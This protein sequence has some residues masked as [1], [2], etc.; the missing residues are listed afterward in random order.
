[1]RVGQDLARDRGE[2]R[3]ELGAVERWMERKLQQQVGAVRDA[4]AP[5]FAPVE[6]AVVADPRQLAGRDAHELG[7][8]G[9]V[10]ERGDP[11]G[12]RDLGQGERPER[13]FEARRIR[14]RGGE[15]REQLGAHRLQRR[16]RELALARPAGDRSEGEPVAQHR[17][18]RAE[19]IEKLERE[20]LAA[21]IVV[22]LPF[23]ALQR[24]ERNLARARGRARRAGHAAAEPDDGARAQER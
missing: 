5:G 7:A 3:V 22:D 2:D 18:G 4:V 13:L 11:I 21:R 15:A 24:F 23:G 8:L 16:R 1:V 12:A 19:A 17:L 10:E 6:A 9:V 14:R 20:T